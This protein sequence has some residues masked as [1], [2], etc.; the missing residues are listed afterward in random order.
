M[1]KNLL[2]VSSKKKVKRI[3]PRGLDQKYLGEEPT[4][5]NQ[6][7]LTENEIQSKL[8]AAYNWYNYFANPKM[9]REFL[10][11][12]MVDS[13]MSKAAVQMMNKVDDHHI[14]PSTW[15]MARM[16]T[17][18][19]DAPKIRRE[20]LFNDITEIVKRGIAIAE[21]EKPPSAMSKSTVTNTFLADVES[22]IDANDEQL[23]KFYEF[24]Q[25]KKPKP[26]I[27][28]DI[29]NY[30]QPWVDELHL[31]YLGKGRNGDLQLREAYE[32]M[33]KK[34]IKERIALFEGIINDCKSYVGNNRKAVVRKP[35]KVKPKSDTVIVK[36]LKYQKEDVELK[37][38]S[39]DPTK[40]IGAKELWTFNTKYNVLAHYVS[41]TGLS[42]KGTTL[43]NVNDKLSSQKKLRKPDQV[44]PDIT[45]STSKAAIRSFE[46]LTTKASVP[47]GRIAD[48][49]IILRAVK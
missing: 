35:R 8:A 20:I 5:E 37:I 34:Q 47:N 14:L 42:V 22:M 21:A 16:I 44:L 26:A 33:T 39:I 48:T 27:V 2:S 3:T 40:I 41:D 43:Q 18:G 7:L 1:A 9:N 25:N 49:S 31:A 4:W 17:M 38:V 28:T 12:F 30:Y 46:A 29:A 15:K 19:Y 24:L 10:E 11:E 32:H 6:Q 36:S 45:G 23:T 13:G